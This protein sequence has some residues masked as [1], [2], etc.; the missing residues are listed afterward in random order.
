MVKKK[1]S[2]SKFS[3]KSVAQLADA[4]KHWFDAFLKLIPRGKSRLEFRQGGLVYAQGQHA[5]AVFFVERGK[6]RLSVRSKVGQDAI[7]GTLK[8]GGFC[9]E[10]CLSGQ[11]LRVGS[12]IAATA[13][14]VVKV[15]KADL[16][17]ALRDQHPLSEVLLAKLL[18]RNISFEADICDQLFDHSEK[19]LARALL[20]LARFGQETAKSHSHTITPTISREALAEMI[21]ATRARVDFFINKFR[22]LG[23]IDCGG[24]T[25]HGEIHV[26]PELLTDVVLSE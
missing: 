18:A 11:P 4:G 15:R 3:S 8:P 25:H 7:L 10:G 19:R 9:G 13:A 20:K 23:L 1:A 14:T 12:A 21:G 22:R 16:V 26:R 6:V 5:D 17:Q 2:G 24:K